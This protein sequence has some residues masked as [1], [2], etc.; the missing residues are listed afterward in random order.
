MRQVVEL[1]IASMNNALASVG[2]VRG[3]SGES[4]ESGENASTE[5]EDQDDTSPSS[6]EASAMSCQ[7]NLSAKDRS[8][9]I[10]SCGKRRS[11]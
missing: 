9:A 11:S 6:R 3:E 5:D 1:L 8:R 10:G 7:T 4:G 2:F